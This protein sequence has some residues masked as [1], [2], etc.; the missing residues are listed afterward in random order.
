MTPA[1]PIRSSPVLGR[2]PAGEGGRILYVGS[3]NG[4]LYALD[5]RTGAAPLVVRHHARGSARCATATTSTAHRRW[6]RAASTSAGSTAGWSTSPT[7]IACAAPATLAATRAPARRSASGLTRRPPVTPGGNTVARLR[8]ALPAATML[9]GRLVVRRR[10]GDRRRIDDGRRLGVEAGQDQPA[11]RLHRAALWRRALPADRPEGLPAAGHRLSGA[12][13]RRLCG[14]GNAGGQ[15][16]RRRAQGGALRQHASA[17]VR[18][19]RA[20]RWRS[21]RGARGSAR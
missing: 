21:R 15:H 12:R 13:L 18:R 1:T 4:S 2:A 6:A 9:T 14:G 5:A 7:T 8:G 11:L 10:R 19:A 16:D 17:S 3:S 20:A